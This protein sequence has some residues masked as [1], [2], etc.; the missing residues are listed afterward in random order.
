MKEL[1]ELLEKALMKQN[2]EL[3]ALKDFDVEK[4]FSCGNF[5]ASIPT[6]STDQ[7]IYAGS[8]LT[9][10]AVGAKFTGDVDA[11]Q[12]TV[13]D[14]RDFIERRKHFARITELSYTINENFDLLQEA[15]SL[16]TQK[17]KRE[18]FLETAVILD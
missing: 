7:L 11:I 13:Q 2:A 18:M 16:L 6:L 17:E 15:K 14:Q 12:Q 4:T 9:S 1:L 3:K 10:R 8:L 5:S